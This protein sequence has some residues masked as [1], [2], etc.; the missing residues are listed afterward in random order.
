MFTG[1]IESM[2]KLEEIV[3]ENENI[4][5]TFSCKFLQELQID[6]SVAH[7]GVCLTVIDITATTYTVTA[8]KETL[9]LSNLGKLKIGNMVNLERC[10]PANGRFDGHIVQGHVD[11]IATCINTKDENGSTIFTFEC[12]SKKPLIVHKGSICINGISLT[13]VNCSDNTFSVAIIP[14][15]IEHTNLHSVTAGTTVNIEFDIIGKY[16]ARI[17]GS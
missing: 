14:Y 16:L 12:E 11:E 4:H 17:H 3:K 5:F 15:T 2:G 8:I 13:V 1:I 7:N 10:M 6:Q 9:N